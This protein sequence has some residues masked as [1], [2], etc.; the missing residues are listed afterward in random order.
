VTGAAGKEHCVEPA[1]TEEIRGRI[2]AE[3]AEAIR[4]V[5]ALTVERDGIIDSVSDSNNDDEHDP[6]GATS[7][8][9]R[10]KTT[11]MLRQ[12]EER[13][14]E[15]DRAAARLRDGTY[16]RCEEC[17]GEIGRERL[18]ARVFTTRCVRCAA[19]PRSR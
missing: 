7:G 8:Y 16:G 13:L 5:E 14:A 11:A 6:D 9:E 2:A 17:G 10:A 1:D 15:L 4:L 3:R 18:E 12:A 19:T